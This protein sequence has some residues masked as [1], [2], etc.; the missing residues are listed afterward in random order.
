MLE[1]QL[2]MPLGCKVVSRLPVSLKH[3]SSCQNPLPVRELKV[4]TIPDIICDID[5]DCNPYIKIL[6]LIYLMEQMILPL[7]PCLTNNCL[8]K[9]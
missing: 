8:F 2:K 5:S 6:Y 9:S 4:L 1:L 3:L 7:S